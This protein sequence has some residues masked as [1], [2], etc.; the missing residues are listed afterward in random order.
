MFRRY[1]ETSLR[2]RGRARKPALAWPLP[3][4]AELADAATCATPQGRIS[5]LCRAES[6]AAGPRNPASAAALVW[7]AS[8]ERRVK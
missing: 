3:R 6:F 7:H 2:Y 8:H 4:P 5:S 1:S